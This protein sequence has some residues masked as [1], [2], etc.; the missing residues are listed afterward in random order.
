MLSLAHWLFGFV[1]LFLSIVFKT[2]LEVFQVVKKGNQTRGK[3]R[4]CPTKQQ[5]TNPGYLSQG[6]EQ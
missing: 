3:R 5:K 4:H 6:V 1:F 2:V